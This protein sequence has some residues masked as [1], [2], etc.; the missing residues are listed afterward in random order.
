MASHKPSPSPAS[1][2]RLCGGGEIVIRQFLAADA[3]QVHA[4]LVEGLVHGVDSPR[5]TALRKILYSSVG[6]VGVAGIVIGISCVAG[7]TDLGLR[8]LGATLCLCGISTFAYIQRTVTNFFGRLCT[9]AR[10][11]DMADIAA[12]Y[13][14]PRAGG[15]TQCCGGFW[16]AAIVSGDGVGSEIVG[17]IGLEY[18]PPGSGTLR[19]MF[20]SAAHRRRGIGR[21]LLDT[22]INHARRT[23]P[24]IV[25]L[26]LDTSEFQPAAMRFYEQHGFDIE[27]TYCMSLGVFLPMRMYMY[28]RRVDA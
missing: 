5:N 3:Q 8:I 20:V 17:C 12:A 4:I 19:R 27:R 22:A 23:S 24:P 6:L 9:V 11:T 14:I 13:G 18:R 28:S 15:S 10:A 21:M 1:I 7:S 2:P 26:E 25:K 16:V